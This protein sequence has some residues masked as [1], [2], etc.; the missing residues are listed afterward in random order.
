VN[1]TIPAR[2]RAVAVFSGWTLYERPPAEHTPSYSP[3][4]I[5][6]KLLAPEG[7]PRR[8]GRTRAFW[9]GWNALELRLVKNAARFRLRA[10][11]PSVEAQ[12]VLFLELT[13]NRAWLISAGG[14]AEEEIDTEVARLAAPRTARSRA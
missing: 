7:T 4:W 5:N 3:L 2:S 14:V 6:F 10:Q 1:P 13:Y 12:V 9:L 8:W 11:E